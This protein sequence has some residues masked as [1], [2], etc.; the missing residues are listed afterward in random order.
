[1]IKDSYFSFLIYVVECYFFLTTILFL[2]MIF[3]IIHNYQKIKK[4]I[5]T[6]EYQY[7]QEQYQITQHRN[8]YFIELKHDFLYLKELLRKNHQNNLIDSINK[9]T[10]KIDQLDTRIYT[11]NIMMNSFLNRIKEIY[12]NNIEDIYVKF[13]QIDN[14]YLIEMLLEKNIFM[15]K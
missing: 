6:I 4:E 2:F 5:K 15:K 7:I 1:M 13:Y 12:Q 9:I 11:D 3:I 14:L 10:Q 8:Q